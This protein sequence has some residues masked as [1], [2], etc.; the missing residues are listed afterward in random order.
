MANNVRVKFDWIEG[1]L[2]E[3]DDRM[4]G[5]RLTGVHGV[6]VPGAFGERGSEG[7]IRAV[8]F[9]RVHETSSF[10]HLLRHARWR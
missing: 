4:I 5:E 6:L 9:A 10:R 2:F 3:R 7:M 1:G 8:Q